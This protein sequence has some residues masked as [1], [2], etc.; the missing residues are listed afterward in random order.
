MMPRTSGFET[1]FQCVDCRACD[2][3]CPFYL[4]SGSVEYGPWSK[5]KAVQGI[6]LGSRD[7]S[8][9]LGELYSCACCGTCS[10]VCPAGVR[11]DELVRAARA[12]AVERGLVP[13][14]IARMCKSIIE[15]GSIAGK[16]EAWG[17]WLPGGRLGPERGEYAYACGC[18]V[19]LRMGEI[20]RAALALM[21]AAGLKTVALG[22][23]ERCCGLPLLD[24]GYGDELRGIAERNTLAVEERGARVLVT[25]CPACYTM[26]R[27]FYP[28]LYR[29][30]RY[31]VLHTVDVL[32]DLVHSGKLRPSREIRVKAAFLD[33]C[34][35]AKRDKR[36]DI[37]RG[38][39]ES[40]PGLKL[41]ELGRS[42]DTGYCCG[43]SGGTKLMFRDLVDRASLLILEDAR[44]AGASVVVT[45]C[46]AC[47]YQLSSAARRFEVRDVSVANLTALLAE[48]CGINAR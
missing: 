39:L 34:H 28:R 26:Y 46:P 27:H 19:A 36:Y 23:D 25:E 31:R 45:A 14:G 35:Y 24:H 47:T 30:P 18:M 22:R 8:D 3:V 17:L 1:A 11:V 44:R 20:G 21:E 42:R 16:P 10:N 43:I 29:E 41:V 12:M 15:T 5:V 48:A 4:A 9:V 2:E 7:V 33:P 32:Y 40:I 6:L 13:E 37:P 38:L